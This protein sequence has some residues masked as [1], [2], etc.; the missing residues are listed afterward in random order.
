MTAQPA[1]STPTSPRAA[2]QPDTL[3]VGMRLPRQSSPVTCGAAS[4]VVARR[5]LERMPLPSADDLVEGQDFRT[6]EFATFGRT[7]NPWEAR[8]LRFPWP[9]AL[10]TPPWGALAELRQVV[11]TEGL[12][13]LRYGLRAVRTGGAEQLAG[14]LAGTGTHEPA[15]L[16]VGTRW[17]PRH[18]AVVAEDAAGRWALYDPAAGTVVEADVDEL[19]AGIQR[20][21][22]WPV[23]WVVVGPRV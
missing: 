8:A 5:L 1:D 18:V 7:N 22:G 23:P 19:A 16:Y 21:G 11:H 14:A 20:V 4:L 3:A 9:M 12:G 13:H 2:L 17:M 10:G 15:L 6:T